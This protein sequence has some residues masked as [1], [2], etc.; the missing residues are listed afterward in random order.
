MKHDD[1]CVYNPYALDDP[2]VDILTYGHDAGNERLDHF[3]SKEQ[4]QTDD[5]G[6][7]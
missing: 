2:N 6:F 5:G 4:P 1:T 7:T 3:F